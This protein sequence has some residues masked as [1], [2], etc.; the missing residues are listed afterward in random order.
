MNLLAG[1]VIDNFADAATHE[2]TYYHPSE[3]LSR[4]AYPLDVVSTGINRRG[5]EQLNLLAPMP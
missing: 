4:P 1:H 5:Q 2:N 3:L